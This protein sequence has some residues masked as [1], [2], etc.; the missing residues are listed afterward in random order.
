MLG[1]VGKRGAWCVHGDPICNKVCTKDTEYKEM[2]SFS[3]SC[4]ARR[5]VPVCFVYELPMLSVPR[6]SHSQM[7]ICLALRDERRIK[8]LSDERP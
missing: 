7:V 2:T 3:I 8:L 1:F 6:R 4:A 5:L